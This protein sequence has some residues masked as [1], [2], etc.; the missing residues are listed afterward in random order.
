MARILV[1]EDDPNIADFVRR[2]LLQSGFDWVK[3]AGQQQMKGCK[4]PG[5]IDL[6]W[7]SWT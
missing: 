5:S 3:V 2:G 1:V 6:R 7:L 4:L